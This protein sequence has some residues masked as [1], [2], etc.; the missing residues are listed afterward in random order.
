MIGNR[1]ILKSGLIFGAA[2]CLGSMLNFFTS[3]ATDT[4]P[5]INGHLVDIVIIICCIIG[6]IYFYKKY[7]NDGYLHLWQGLLIGF[8][9][10]LVAINLVSLFQYVYLE[11][12]NPALLD[13]YKAY[14]IKDFAI[15]KQAIAKEGSLDDAKRK[16][17][18]F[19]KAQ[20]ADVIIHQIFIKFLPFPIT[21]FTVF[22][23]SLAFRKVEK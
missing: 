19:M 18:G 3:L 4:I 12:I 9:T 21:I 15:K 14:M 16:L 13:Q 11:Y 20:T 17:E 5:F 23:A 1:R 7:L 10:L 6:A 2:A 22:F 8:W